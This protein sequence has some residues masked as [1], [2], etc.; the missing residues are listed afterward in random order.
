MKR[1]PIVV[2]VAG[3]GLVCLV[4]IVVL[5]VILW[6][7]SGL[8]YIQRATGIILPSGISQVDT[9]DNLEYYTVAHVRLR[10]EDIASFRDEYGFSIPDFHTSPSLM[11]VALKPENRV[12]PANADLVYLEGRSESNSWQ[13]ALD[14]NSGRLWIIVFYPDPGGTLH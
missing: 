10:K 8:R 3:I 5:A 2:I 9:F 6:F 4:A 13:C 12:I 11:T 14:Q 7:A 1:R